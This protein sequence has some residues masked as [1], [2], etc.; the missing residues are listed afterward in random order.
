MKVGLLVRVGIDSTSGKWNAPCDGDGRFCYVP[1]GYGAVSADYDPLYRRYER[2]VRSFLRLKPGSIAQSCSWPSKLPLHGHF[3]PDFKELTYGDQG[4]RA[5]RLLRLILPRT[6]FLVF[7]AGLRDVGSGSLVYSIIGFYEVDRILHATD[8]PRTERRR[9]E[10]TRPG[11]FDS[12]GS[13]VVFARRL[14]SGRLSK[15]IPI[16]EMRGRHY[17]VRKEL[18]GAWGNLDV[19]DGYIH[20][21]AFLP[22][23]LNPRKFLRWF[24]RQRPTLLRTDNPARF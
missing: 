14:N 11:R 20:R 21:S 2:A 17:R 15:H 19:E 13:C 18:L 7:Y 1:M 9:N 10:H 23:F 24:D 16:G 6:S 12:S 5:K 22:Q 3:D 4:G 8:V